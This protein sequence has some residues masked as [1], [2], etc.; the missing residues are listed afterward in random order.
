MPYITIGTASQLQIKAPTRGTTNWDETLRTD[1]WIKIAEHDHT[2][3]SGKGSQ[4][5]AAAFANDAIN[6]TK[7]RLDNDEYLRGRNNA[8]S[9]DVNIVK[10]N[11]S[12]LIEFGVALSSAVLTLPQINDTSSD[13]QYVFAVNELAADRTVTL[14]LLTGNDEFVFK[15]HAVTMINKTI[16]ADDNTL[17]GI[18]ASSFVLSDGSG[19][20]DGSASQKAIPS[21]AVVGISDSQTLTNKAIDSDNN[22]ITNIVNADIKAAAAIAVNKLAALTASRAVVSDG[23]GFV[24]AATTT[25]TEIGYVNGVTSAIQTQI[26]SKLPTTLTTTGDIIY[27]SSGSTAAR[28]GVGDNGD[29]LTLAAGVPSW[30]PVSVSPT[31]VTSK[32]TTYTALTTDDTILADTSGGA[33]TLTLYAASGNNGRKIR[34]K[35]TTNDLNILTIDGNA[36]EI[37]SSTTIKL[38]TYLEEVELTCDGSN[39]HVTSSF[40][41]TDWA[42]FTMAITAN[43]TDPTKGTTSVDQAYWRR[44]G[45]DMHIIWTY[46]QTSLGSGAAG[47]GAYRFTIPVSASIDTGKVTASSSGV[48]TVL[49]TGFIAESADF[50]SATIY[51]CQWYAFDSTK[52]ACNFWDQGSGDLRTSRVALASGTGGNLGASTA[53]YTMQAIVPISGW[54]S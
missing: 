24:S 13:H 6:G 46:I 28:L 21:G 11:T 37:D 19:N 49:G 9:A 54:R 8:N 41:N 34:V 23:S 1:T 2:G 43:T 50:Y 42:S 12:D 29:V 17:S 27:S 10:V 53:S 3:T 30:S 52:L 48:A 40:A 47:S 4:L 38:N 31:A 35:K 36:S 44:V 20:I 16:S 26:D 45:S 7:I 25:A 18:A 33:W 51:P 39:W 32:S 15:D 14:P 5:T 22:T